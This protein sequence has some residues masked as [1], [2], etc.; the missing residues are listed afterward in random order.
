MSVLHRQNPMFC[1][2]NSTYWIRNAAQRSV[3]TVFL[4]RTSMTRIR[5]QY[6]CDPTTP[7]RWT[8]PFPAGSLWLWSHCGR[9]WLLFWDERCSGW[10]P[11]AGMVSGIQTSSLLWECFDQ[12]GMGCD[13]AVGRVVVYGYLHRFTDALGWVLEH[14]GVDVESPVATV[15]HKG[16]P[17]PCSIDLPFDGN[18]PLVFAVCLE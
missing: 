4:Y 3:E 12:F 16:L 17:I 18:G 1:G 6:D 11:S 5:D 14:G 13:G 10:F 15:F 8:A 9:C 2:V 7:S